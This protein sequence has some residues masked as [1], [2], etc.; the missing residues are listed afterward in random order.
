MKKKKKFSKRNKSASTLLISGMFLLGLLIGLLLS[1]ILFSS[2]VSPSLLLR[3][4]GY[5]YINPLI[6]FDNIDFI[7]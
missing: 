3:E 2:K 6:D 1:N 5:Q 4:S 7:K